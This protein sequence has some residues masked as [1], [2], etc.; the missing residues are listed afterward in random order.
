MHLGGTEEVVVAPGSFTNTH[1]QRRNAHHGTQYCPP[2][3]QPFGTGRGRGRA[4]TA[5]TVARESQAASYQWV[6]AEIARV[7]RTVRMKDNGDA[8]GKERIKGT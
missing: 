2:P 5:H 7:M 4:D 1:G 8:A 3:R 6:V